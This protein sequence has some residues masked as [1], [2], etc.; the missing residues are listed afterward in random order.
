[1]SA[2]EILLQWF[3]QSL[4]GSVSFRAI[5]T[6]QANHIETECTLELRGLSSSVRY[7]R[8][9]ES[10]LEDKIGRAIVALT[11]KPL[12]KHFCG[13]CCSPLVE[14]ALFTSI[15]LRCEGCGFAVPKYA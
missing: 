11:D 3:T 5:P 2:A 12:P 14:Q 9:R 1:M 10:N 8:F 6:Q 7:D 13:T 4:G 15:E